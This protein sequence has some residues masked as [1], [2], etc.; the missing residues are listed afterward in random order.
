MGACYKVQ[1]S[2]S[3]CC[4]G[5]AGRWHVTRRSLLLLLL[6]SGLGQGNEQPSPRTSEHGGPHVPG[7]ER[8]FEL[9]RTTSNPVLATV[10]STAEPPPDTLL[11]TGVVDEKEGSNTEKLNKHK[12]IAL[13]RQKRN[14]A[15]ITFDCPSDRCEP[16][17]C[18]LA[19]RVIQEVNGG[20]RRRMGDRW[21]QRGGAQDGHE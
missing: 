2:T 9:G 14:R 8:S 18:F 6:L 21:R 16:G 17:N 20:G 15:S 19:P 13:P 5:N 4:R 7:A 1:S 12:L 10:V 11:H 3:G